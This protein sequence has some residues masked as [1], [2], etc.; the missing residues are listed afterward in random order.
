VAART[1][2]GP[3]AFVPGPLQPDIDIVVEVPGDDP[4]WQQRAPARRHPQCPVGRDQDVVAG[5]P[6][7]VCAD[8]ED[9]TA[10]DGSTTQIAA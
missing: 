5:Q 4:G 3:H 2:R 6:R 7:Q 9:V 8:D 1:Q 10:H